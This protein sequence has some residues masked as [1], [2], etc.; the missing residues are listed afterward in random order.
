M[1][2]FLNE[3]NSQQR[4][5][6]EC[7]EGPLLILAGA[8][9]GKT[10]V[11]T[12]RIAHLINDLGVP[13]E[14]ILAVTFTNKAAGQMKERVAK[15]LSGLPAEATPQISTFHSFCVRVLRRDADRLG[16]SRDFSIY[17]DDDQQR[18]VRAAA[19]E[20]GISDQIVSPRA[21]LSRISHAKNRCVS[22]EQLFHLAADAVT[23]K[24]ATLYA[25]YEKKLRE[26]NALDFDDLLLKA[27]QLFETAPE[28]CAAYNERFRYVMV[29]EYQDTNRTQY[30]LIRQLTAKRQN[31]CVVGD[32]DQ[33]I[34]RW[35]G[36]DIENILSFEKDYPRARIVRLERN[37]RSTQIILDAASAVVSNN[38]ARIGKTLWSDRKEGVRLGFYQGRDADEEAAFVT[39]HARRALAADPQAA[40]GILYRTNAQSRPFEEAL[41][42]AELSYQIVGGFRFYER[43][44]IKD[45]LAYARLTL[46]HQDS[47]ALL[48][49]INVPPRGIGAST[50]ATLRISAEH[51]GG[52]LWEAVRQEISARRLPTRSLNAV[53]NFHSV[54]QR[55]ME[56]RAR[57]GL[58]EFFRRILDETGYLK[59]LEAENLPEAQARIENL[60]ELVNAAAEA[61]SR[62]ETL[63][64]FLDHAALVSD[65]DEFNERAR[66][67][68]MT[69]HTAKGLEFS[70]VFLVGMEEGLFPH[71]LSLLD[72]A[73]LEEERRLCYVGMTRAMR[74]LILTRAVHRR[75]Y[76]EDYLRGT[77]S[78]RFLDEIPADLMESLRAEAPLFKS[79]PAWD[80]SLNS[81]ES[82][83]EFLARR[84]SSTPEPPR[85]PVQSP[86]AAPPNSGRWKL[87][88]RVRHL[89]YGFGTIVGCEGEGDDVKLTVSF[90]GYGR[91]KLMER[92]ASLERA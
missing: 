43:A 58:A 66:I 2:D 4:Q 6:V 73:A 55:L 89:K 78:S 15:L 47:A 28:V 37:Y 52:G 72:Q 16:Y 85:P 76:G 24:L 90:P 46:N 5:A 84:R 80:G 21:A 20:L 1:S 53:E 41:H 65:T 32:E 18:L 23:E 62:G 31:I 56:E 17:D 26:A 36:A 11:I 54:M 50:L 34:Y 45:A 79:T 75:S 7:T 51:L 68:L 22:P 92:Y 8:G 59:M 33:S 3:L 86:L 91:K 30:L 40:A 70:S 88:T 35:R 13:P 10:R 38:R 48:R 25:R 87:G 77:R 71:K 42:R 12:Y 19:S 67:T 27:V 57:L 39:E 29:D 9:S 14:A 61:E 81:V 74:Q 44:E 83:E 69:L 82:V 60:Q 64:E 49:I 63:A